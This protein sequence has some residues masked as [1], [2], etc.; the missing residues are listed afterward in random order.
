MTEVQYGL[1]FLCGKEWHFHAANKKIFTLEDPIEIQNDSF[2]QLQINES[3]HLSYAEG[4]KQLMRH[5]PD[6]LMIGEIRDEEAAQMAVRCVLTGHLVLSSIH[7]TDCAT[8]I[9]RMRDLG[10]KEYELKDVL[11]GISNQRLFEKEDGSRIGVYEIM[12]RCVKNL[13][14]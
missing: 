7:S 14:I 10:V 4:I 6:L 12:C 5:D 8:A 13:W 2:V 1:L 3:Q 9:I 11:Y